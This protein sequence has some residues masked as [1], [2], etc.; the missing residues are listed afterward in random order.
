MWHCDALT[1]HRCCQMSHVSAQTA[2]TSNKGLFHSVDLWLKD[3]L[4]SGAAAGD[5]LRKY[6]GLLA[7][8]MT[9]L[10]QQRAKKSH[11][12]KCYDWY[13]HNEPTQEVEARG[14][15]VWHAGDLM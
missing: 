8:Q 7:Q 15:R 6:Q 12:Q 13:Q 10:G 14:R 9:H 3:G 5:G 1:G 11:I 4:T 2:A